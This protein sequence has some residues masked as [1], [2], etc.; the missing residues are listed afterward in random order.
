M[1]Y[2]MIHEDDEKQH[3]HH[4]TKKKKLL[5]KTSCL[6]TMFVTGVKQQW[7]KNDLIVYRIYT[8]FYNQTL[9]NYGKIR[10]QAINVQYFAVFFNVA[11][12]RLSV[13]MLVS[14]DYCLRCAVNQHTLQNNS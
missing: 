3:R 13:S 12:V 8:M 14:L 10:H 4:Q 6:F 7:M 11:A 9:N 2:V 1:E 5:R